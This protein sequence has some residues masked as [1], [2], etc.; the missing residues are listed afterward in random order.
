MDIRVLGPLEVLSGDTAVALGGPKQRAVLAILAVHGNSL[1]SA[2][3]LVD[4]V[5]GET[6]LKSARRT[7]HSYIAN[8]RRLL[9]VHGDVL[10]G[11]QGGYVLDADA[12]NVDAV[13]FARNVKTARSLYAADPAEAVSLL[14]ETLAMWRGPPFGALA[15]DIPSLRIESA[16]LEELRLVAMELRIDCELEIGR[17]GP[18]VGDLEGLVVEHP[19]R[20]GLWRRLMLALYRSGR[21]GEALSAYQRVRRILSEELGIEPSRE[22]MRLEDQILLQDPALDGRSTETMATAATSVPELVPASLEKRTPAFLS[23]DSVAMETSESVFVS[24]E[25]ELVRLDR[26]LDNALGSVGQPVFVTGEA[27]TGKTAL[28]GE[29]VKRAQAA[30]PGLVVASGTCETLTGAGD[31]YLPFREIMSLLTGDCESSWAAGAITRDHALRLWGL[32]PT[33]VEAICDSGTTLMDGFIPGQDLVDRAR[34]FGADGQLSL[35]R[36]ERL[37]AAGAAGRSSPP[38]EQHRT[39]AEYAAVL[40]EIAARNPLVV[41]IDDLHWADASS[42]QL[43]SYLNRRLDGRRIL[44]IGTYRPED[45]A[46]G[47]GGEAHPLTQVITDIKHRR[48]D[49]FVDLDRAEAAEGRAFV[50]AL[51][52]AE[53][54]ALSES[55]R[56]QL[57]ERSGGRALFAVE[58]LRHVQLRGDLRRDAEGR[59]VERGRISWQTLPARV[60]GVIER[61]FARLDPELQDALLTASVEGIEF[62]AEVV[63]SVQALEESTLIHRL[64]Q[65]AGQQHRLVEARGAI[66]TGTQRVSRYRFRHSLFREFLYASLDPVEHAHRH[67]AVGNALEALHRPHTGDVAARLASHFHKAG[68]EDKAGHY[69]QQAG[70]RSMGLAANAE[71]VGYY[72]EAL[73][74]LESQ[75]DTSGRAH[76]EL[77]ILIN[78]SLPLQ[79]T[80]GYWADE[81]EVVFERARVLGEDLSATPELFAALRGLWHFHHSRLEFDKAGELADRLLSLANRDGGD[82]VLVVQAHRVLG[83]GAFFRGDFVQARDHLEQAIA[84]YDPVAHRSH[85]YPGVLDPGIL[86]GLN[87]ATSLW[88]LG[89]PD[90]ASKNMAETLEL[91]REQPSSNSFVVALGVAAALHVYRRE[92]EAALHLADEKIEIASDIGFEIQ[93]ATARADRGAALANLGAVEDGIN[94]MKDGLKLYHGPFRSRRMTELAE[95][96]WKADQASEGLAMVTGALALVDKA[97]GYFTEAELWRVKG[98]LELLGGDESQA[99]DSFRTAIDTA[100]RQGARSFELRAVTSMTRLRQRQGRDGEALEMLEEIYDWFTEGLQT[101]DLREAKTLLDQLNAVS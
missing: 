10:H 9:N 42:V 29:F 34:A 65:E 98:E 71:A 93:I 55:F 38:A 74:I 99:G 36:L 6:P 7:L 2:D 73:H 51:V 62:T 59:W 80:Q 57:T 58:L 97:G 23:E 91:A 88:I 100:R 75:P 18:G 92:G 30:H 33:V 20:E 84:G 14:D 72:T 69:L 78:L 79:M 54:N 40:E 25:D 96:H 37:V 13:R 4:Q 27:G 95:A 16:R 46:Q 90:L 77:T 68:I 21:Q 28:L 35:A 53:P 85:P 43:F 44:L 89:Y 47:R 12:V 48:G 3:H 64:S 17:D 32:L 87:A 60:E 94:L 1:V 22:L 86:S 19:Y 45:V 70:N 50:D 66:R 83:E 101:G 15:D 5:W 63:A 82:P 31:P 81:V 24:R 76:R 67:E 61:L 26:F 11:R 49:I 39:F 8:L 56:A 41:V 52:D